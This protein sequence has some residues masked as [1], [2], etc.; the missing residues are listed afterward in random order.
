MDFCCCWIKSYLQSFKKM[1]NKLEKKKGSKIVKENADK[2]YEDA[3]KHYFDNKV[4]I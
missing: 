4:K 3:E 1:K 2:A